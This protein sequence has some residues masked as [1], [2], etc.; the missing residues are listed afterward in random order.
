[1]KVWVFNLE[2]KEQLISSIFFEKFGGTGNQGWEIPGRLKNFPRPGWCYP[3]V[4]FL[5]DCKRKWRSINF[6]MKNGKKRK[7]C[8][9]W[10]A[11]RC[12]FTGEVILSDLFRWANCSWKMFILNYDFWIN[13][14]THKGKMDLSEK[15]WSPS[16]F[17]HLVSLASSSSAEECGVI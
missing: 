14:K 12:W 6:I 3:N 10:S 17:V 5:A 4:H 16:K 2:K 11:E 8:R 7:K 1:M 13:G 9:C 15:I